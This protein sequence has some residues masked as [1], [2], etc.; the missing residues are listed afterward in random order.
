VADVIELIRVNR[1]EES[2]AE[3]LHPY[4][5]EKFRDLWQ[6]AQADDASAG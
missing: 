2:F 5:R 1:V 4:V 3:S 6:A